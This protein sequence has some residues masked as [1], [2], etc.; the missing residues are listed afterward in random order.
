[1]TLDLDTLIIMTDIGLPG[2]LPDLNR[3][4]INFTGKF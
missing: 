1:M 2:V 4:M 3:E